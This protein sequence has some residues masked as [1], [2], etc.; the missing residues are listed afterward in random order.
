MRVERTVGVADGS[1]VVEPFGA[2]ASAPP[3]A[4]LASFT[5]VA[6]VAPLEDGTAMPE[7]V[8][9]EVGVG[10]GVGTAVSVGDGDGGSRPTPATNTIASPAMVRRMLK[11]SLPRTRDRLR[12]GDLNDARFPVR[13]APHCEPA[14]ESI[15]QVA[16]FASAAQVRH[17]KQTTP[18]SCCGS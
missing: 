10:V 3:G 7:V 9:L 1:T 16:F 17:P 6:P 5:P 11:C 15:A 14:A 2:V 4:A 13:S 18:W 8:G 12:C